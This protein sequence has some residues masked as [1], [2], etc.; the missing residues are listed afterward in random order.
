VHLPRDIASDSWTHPVFDVVSLVVSCMSAGACPRQSS[1][2]VVYT[3]LRSGQTT[4][5]LVSVTEK[6]P[7]RLALDLGGITLHPCLI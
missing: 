4:S 5:L 1:A 6:E 3:W 2:G 7:V